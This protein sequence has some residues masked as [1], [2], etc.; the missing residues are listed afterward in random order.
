MRL[1]TSS[2]CF[3]LDKLPDSDRKIIK[4]KIKEQRK[5]MENMKF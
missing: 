3:K 2:I 5:I 1:D 4:L